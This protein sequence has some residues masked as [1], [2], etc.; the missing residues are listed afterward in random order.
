MTDY[1]LQ[2]CGSD[3]ASAALS[4]VALPGVGLSYKQLTKTTLFVCSTFQF[5]SRQ[6]LRPSQFGGQACTEPLVDSRLCFPAKL[7]N[8][9]EVDCKN[10]FRCESGNDKPHCVTAVLPFIQILVLRQKTSILSMYKFQEKWTREKS[11]C[12]DFICISNRFFYK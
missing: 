9:V 8:I 5:R 11:L 7:C 10:K 4:C 1:F 2:G 3:K 12:E 6:L